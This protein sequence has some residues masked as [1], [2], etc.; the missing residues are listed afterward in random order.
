LGAGPARPVPVSAV[1]LARAGSLTGGVPSAGPRSPARYQRVS[2]HAVA[3]IVAPSVSRKLN[4]PVP[5]ADS[6][7]AMVAASAAL[8]VA[9][10]RRPS[11]TSAHSRA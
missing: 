9:P 8:G 2:P 10:A 6:T 11:R 7:A 3:A 1:S 5:P 4:R